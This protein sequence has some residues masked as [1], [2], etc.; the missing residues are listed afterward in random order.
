MLGA[1]RD[2]FFVFRSRLFGDGSGIKKAGE[3]GEESILL[4]SSVTIWR[5]KGYLKTVGEERRYKK[6]MTKSF[7][8]G[9]FHHFGRFV[10]T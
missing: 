7:S 8:T 6:E 1:K 3:K 9:V 5:W 10:C 2:N 4:R